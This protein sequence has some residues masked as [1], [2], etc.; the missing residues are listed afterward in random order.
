H[1]SDMEK[2]AVEAE[3]EAVKVKQLQY[4]KNRLGDEFYGIISGVRP[5]GI[6]IEIEDILAEGLIHI[7]NMDDDYYNYDEDSLSLYGLHTGKSY[8]LGDRIKVQVVNVN[9]EEKQ[10][11]LLLL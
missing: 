8:R 4:M 3:R 11:D 7:R 10:L 2:R 6:F 5:Y 9:L 1:S